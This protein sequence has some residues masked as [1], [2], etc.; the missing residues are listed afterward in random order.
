[1]MI[2]LIVYRHSNQEIDDFSRNFINYMNALE[3]YNVLTS[4]SRCSV[5]RQRRRVAL[6]LVQFPLQG[7][8]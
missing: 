1:M 4:R 2:T 6:L 8:T 3:K 5:W 7:L